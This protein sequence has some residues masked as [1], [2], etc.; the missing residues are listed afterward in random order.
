MI[1]KDFFANTESRFRRIFTSINIYKMRKFNNDII[2]SLSDK[3]EFLTLIKSASG[4]NIAMEIG[5]LFDSES[6]EVFEIESCFLRLQLSNGCVDER[7][8]NFLFELSGN[9]C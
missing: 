2:V 7:L 6:A 1:D 9:S 3:N 8:E 4:A 5:W